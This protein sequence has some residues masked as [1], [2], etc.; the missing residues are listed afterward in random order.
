[1]FREVSVTF[2]RARG[3]AGGRSG[4]AAAG[5]VPGSVPNDSSPRVRDP[6]STGARE[7]EIIAANPVDDRGASSRRTS[8]RLTEPGGQKQGD[9]DD[10]CEKN[11]SEV[12][13]QHRPRQA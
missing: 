2:A 9:R 13:G 5:P 4:A 8:F 10:A 1:M 6:R 7:L 11:E 3:A 12:C